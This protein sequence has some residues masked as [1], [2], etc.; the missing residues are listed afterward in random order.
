MTTRF[1]LIVSDFSARLEWHA[2]RL[3]DYAL[4]RV[5]R[6]CDDDVERYYDVLRNE[7]QDQDERL[8]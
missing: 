4:K 5:F 7:Y 1:W 6:R 3:K 2:A 8:H